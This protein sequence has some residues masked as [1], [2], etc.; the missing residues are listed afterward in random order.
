MSE[1]RLRIPTRPLCHRCHRYITIDV[2]VDDDLWREVIG[3]KFGPGYIC[4]DCFTR[5]ADER[6]IHWDTKVRFIP[7]CLAM[8]VEVQKRSP[9]QTS[10]LVSCLA[11]TVRETK[12]KIQQSNEQ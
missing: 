2:Q 4:A 6:L 3:E 5:A 1:D 7:L 12:A 9:R 10:S 8:Q 11:E